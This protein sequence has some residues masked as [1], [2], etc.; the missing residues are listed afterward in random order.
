VS[1]SE[2]AGAI[3]SYY[4]L[5]PKNTDE[6]WP[7]MTATYQARHAGG[8]SSYDAFWR[9]IRRVSA[10]N[11]TGAAP[12]RAQAT[13]TYEYRDGRRIR[14]RTSFQLVKDGGRLKINDSTVLGSN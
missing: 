2:L 11:V 13:I 3:Q 14:E 1:D 4:A 6:A 8:R 7:G 10:S 9:A 12:D 5:L